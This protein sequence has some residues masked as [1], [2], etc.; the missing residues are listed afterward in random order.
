MK[1]GI[2][3][4]HHQD[5]PGKKTAEIGRGGDGGQVRGLADPEEPRLRENADSNCSLLGN[6]WKG[7]NSI[8]ITPDSPRIALISV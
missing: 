7:G 4:I 1:H 6:P 8:R 3:E 2:L 5:S